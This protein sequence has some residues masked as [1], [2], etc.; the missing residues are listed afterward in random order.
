[1]RNIIAF[2][3][4]TTVLAVEV[5]RLEMSL[6]DRAAL[7]MC[8]VV[9]QLLHL[10]SDKKSLLC[11]ALDVSE[12]SELLRLAAAVGPHAALLK[13]HS[14]IVSDWTAETASQLRQ[15][16]KQHNF[17]V[18]EDRWVPFIVT[19]ACFVAKSKS[20]FFSIFITVV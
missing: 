4:H 18:M 14:D 13:T 3:N 17:L 11:V 7:T 2:V 5:S 8:P 12:A 15:L 6:A 1:M 10:M 16:A 9:G 19:K 20:N